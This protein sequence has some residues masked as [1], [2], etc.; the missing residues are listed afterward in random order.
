MY[1]TLQRAKAFIIKK[2]KHTRSIRHPQVLT[3]PDDLSEVVQQ[4]VFGELC[5][6]SIQYG[7]CSGE[8]GSTPAVCARLEQVATQ[9]QAR[10]PGC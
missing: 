7:S 6:V 2:L 8:L 10:D 5:R 1:C 9:L 4:I 3:R